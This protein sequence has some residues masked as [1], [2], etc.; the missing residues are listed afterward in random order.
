MFQYFTSDFDH[1]LC[2]DALRNA[3]RST[4]RDILETW[5]RQYF[6]DPAQRTPYES[7]EGGYIWIWG[8]PYDAREQLERE[9][10]GVVPDDLIEELADELENECFLWAP[11]PSADNYDQLLDDI[12]SISE[13]YHNFSSAIIDISHLLETDIKTYVPPCFFRMLYVNVVTALETY[14]SDAFI[15]IVLNNSDLLRQFIETTPEFKTRKVSVAD[16]F[17]AAETAKLRARTSLI[18]IVWHNIDRVRIMYRDTLGIRFPDEWKEIARAV[19][20]RH[21]IVHRNGKTTDGNEI[22]IGPGDVS[23]LVRLVEEFVQ[24]ID[25]ECAKLKS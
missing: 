13:Y 5:F 7:K 25:A 3:H 19:N 23:D 1:P 17:R 11:T 16:V 24:S 18:N 15:N 2:R 12:S 14:F 4:Q 22:H 21:D 9:F 10:S 8:G 6:E 20:I